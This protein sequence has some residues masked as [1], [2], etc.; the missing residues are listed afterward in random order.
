MKRKNFFLLLL[1]FA[2]GLAGGFFLNKFFIIGLATLYGQETERTH[3]YTKAVCNEKNEC[4]DFLIKCVNGELDS[5]ESIS[6][7]IKFSPEWEDPR[8]EKEKFC[9]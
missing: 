3:T 2:F 5:M 8:E 1:I 4:M 9:D 6:E 7:V